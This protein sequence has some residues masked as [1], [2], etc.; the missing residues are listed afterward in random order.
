VLPAHSVSLLI[1]GILGE[2][3]RGD[4]KRI[5]WHVKKPLRMETLNGR[6]SQYGME[7][8]SG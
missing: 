8:E 5:W 6:Y 3:N 2:I 7:E 4:T 1:I